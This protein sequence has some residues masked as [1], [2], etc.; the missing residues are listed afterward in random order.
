MSAMS[1]IRTTIA[2]VLGKWPIYFLA[3]GLAISLLWLL[4]LV[5]LGL[6]LLHLV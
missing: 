4:A 6:R 3:F 2:K 1:A 5:W